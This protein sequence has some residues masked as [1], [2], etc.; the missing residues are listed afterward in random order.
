MPELPEIHTIAADL[1]EH[2]LGSLIKDLKL[3]DESK[4]YSQ[5]KSEGPKLI[6]QQ[7]VATARHGKNLFL[8]TSNNLFIN[9]H[10]AMTGQILLKPFYSPNPPHLKI[11]FHL[12]KQNKNFRLLFCD[13]RMFGKAQVLN[14]NQVNQ[15]KQKQG[16]DFILDSINP[17]AFWRSLNKKKTPIKKFLLDQ[18]LY[19]GLGNIYANEALWLAKIN[20]LRLSSS[21][22]FDEANALLVSIKNVLLEGIKHRGSTLEDKMYV[23]IFGKFGNYQ[24][25]FKVYNKNLCQRCKTKIEIKKLDGRATY[26]CPK[27]QT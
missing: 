9:F 18:S 21:L 25:H 26:F 12:N 6:N 17:Q 1:K 4:I 23:D 27:C 15:L 22:T 8:K 5:I 16:L 24:K 19:S 11:E 2:I 20:P 7:I 14:P 10:L 13:M 3:H